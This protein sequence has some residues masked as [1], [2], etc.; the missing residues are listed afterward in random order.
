[1]NLWCRTMDNTWHMDANAHLLSCHIFTVAD[2]SGLKGL[3]GLWR[4]SDRKGR[5]GGCPT[6]SAT[7]EASAQRPAMPRASQCPAQSRL[8]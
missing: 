4:A 1:M 2:Y 3:A 5:T 6:G 8:A 7:L